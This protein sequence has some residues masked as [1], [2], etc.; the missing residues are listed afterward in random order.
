MLR[1]ALIGFAVLFALALLGVPGWVALHRG[2]LPAVD[3]ADLEAEPVAL[4]P[5]EDGFEALREAAAAVVWPDDG[6]A[7]RRLNALLHRE[8][9]DPDWLEARLREN[10]AAFAALERGLAAPQVVVPVFDPADEDCCD[11]WLSVQILV[12][13]AAARAQLQQGRGDPAG[14][15]ESALLGMRAGHALSEAH[16]PDLLSMMVG[17]ACQQISLRAL[18]GLLREWSPSRADARDIAARLASLRWSADAWRRAWAT[19][20]RFTRRLALEAD[21]QQGAEMSL[22]EPEG[23]GPRLL[24]WLPRDYAYQP[25]RT[26]QQFAGLYRELARRGS[27]NC[28]DA[29]ARSALEDDLVAASDEASSPGRTLVKLL[30]PNPVGWLLFQITTPNF[31]EFDVRRCHVETRISLVQALAAL[32]AY[33]GA[34]GTL[35]ERLDALVP[36]WLPAVPEDRFDG[37][38]LRYAR[39]DAVVY[40][41]GADQRDDGPPAEPSQGDAGAPAISLAPAPRPSGGGA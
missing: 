1:R 20:Y 23:I 37:A 36:D 29:H 4:A 27:L 9:W 41:I 12:Q 8:A 39:A 5:G 15:L 26:L 25:N 34:N 22:A 14:A 32:T 11:V 2:D 40:S 18:E 30:S 10:A 35:P 6:Q 7:D 19:E 28:R 31:V 16:G 21:E 13:L 33:R 38:P 24:Q 17:A 3:D